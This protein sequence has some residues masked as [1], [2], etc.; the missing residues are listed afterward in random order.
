MTIKVIQTMN[1]SKEK[2][3][4][5]E[6]EA[7]DF[8]KRQRKAKG[9]YT[10]INE[11]PVEKKTKEKKENWKD[12]VD[13]TDAINV[14]RENVKYYYGKSGYIKVVDNMTGEVKHIGKTTNMGKVFSNYV[15]CAKYNQSYDFDLN[16][17]DR[18]YFKESDLIY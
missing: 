4:A 10:M 9:F 7:L 3:F 12:K 14:N 15:N 1:P 16:N 8:I 13:F 6:Q 18:L 11:K 2:L 5:N 17:S